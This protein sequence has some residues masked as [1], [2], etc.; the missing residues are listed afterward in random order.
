MQ[1]CI[2]NE[3]SKNK[4]EELYQQFILNTLDDFKQNQNIS[5]KGKILHYLPE[6]TFYYYINVLKKTNIN[7]FD[8]NILFCVEFINGEIPYVTILTDFIEPSL[9]DNRNFF[10][11]LTKEHNYIFSLNKYSE[12]RN[13]LK[14]IILGIKNFLKY[15]REIIEINYFVYLGEY[16]LRH[17]YQINDFLQNNNNI[18]YRIFE[19]NNNNEYFEKYIIF[20]NLYFI[21]FQP[22][23]FDKCLI[24]IL[25][26]TE[27][28]EINLIFDK[29]KENNSL[30]LDL[31]ET[32]YKK[33]LEFVI[34]DRKHILKK[35]QGNFNF[36]KEKND[37]E[38]DYS[39]LIQRWFT[40]QNKNIILLKKYNS[41]IKN[42]RQLFNE[43]RDKLEIISGSI[44]SIEE[45]DKIIELYENL[46]KY[47]ENKGEN[48]LE[49]NERI[50]EIISNL[51]YICSELVNYD[52]SK[53]RFD[54]K[55]LK[56]IKKYIDIYK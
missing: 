39:S 12:I 9:N 32:I 8:S 49:N 14:I 31:T 42:Y 36:G 46:L 26:I 13:I 29:N 2:I 50:H 35:E 15:V 16:E 10:R 52:K 53:S 41:I 24:K 6:P 25:Y 17:I 56:K 3:I 54:N 38:Y 19:T 34:I 28:N 55:Y 48:N 4:K 18:L 21:I 22:L 20:T 45:F 23:E 47:Y 7:P 30:I 51:V 11:C 1:N 44:I 27:L 37:I 40:H 5:V 43:N 33:K